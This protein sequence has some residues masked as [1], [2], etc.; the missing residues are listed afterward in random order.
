MC[1]IFG[2][3][4]TK[5]VSMRTVFR[6][7][8]KLEVHQ[9][10]NEPRPVGGYGAGIAILNEEGNVMFEKVGK[11]GDFP[12]EHLAKVVRIGEASILVGHVRMPSPHFMETARFKETAQPYAAKCCRDLTVVSVHNGYVTNYREIRAKLGEAHILESEKVELIDSEVIPHYFE[13]LLKEE[14]DASKA[15]DALYLG[16]EGSMALSLLHVESEMAFLHIAHK[17]KTRGL[18]VW[19]NKQN[20]IIFC[21]R[22]EA[23]NGEL[24]DVFACGKFTERIAVPCNEEFS[25]KLSFPLVSRVKA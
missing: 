9:Y 20:E 14:N 5:P 15:L 11:I 21:S 19:A 18:H 17:G 4:L 13:E 7:L 8:S 22:T 12:A 10:P 6:V 1:G 24:D 25:V 23:L 3:T 16:L 2:F